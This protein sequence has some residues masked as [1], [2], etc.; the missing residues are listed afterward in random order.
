[1]ED[2]PKE[3][4]NSG[5]KDDKKKEKSADKPK[6]KPEPEADGDEEDDKEE[7][8]EGDDAKAIEELKSEIS[9]L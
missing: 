9:G 8:S 3:I 7:S 6:P 4:C 5:K 1:M 2:L